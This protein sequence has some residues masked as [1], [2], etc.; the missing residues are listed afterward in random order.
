[1]DC[2]GCRTLTFLLHITMTMHTVLSRSDE[3][4]TNKLPITDWVIVGVVTLMIVGVI[5]GIIGDH[6][7]KSRKT[8]CGY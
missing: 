4:L 2:V 5:V 7:V 6:I 3:S 1:M 8:K